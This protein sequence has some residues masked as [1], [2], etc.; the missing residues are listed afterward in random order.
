MTPSKMKV[1]FTEKSKPFETLKPGELFITP[2][3]E[4]G[5][6]TWGSLNTWGGKYKIRCTYKVIMS[7]GIQKHEGDILLGF[8]FPSDEPANDKVYGSN[9]EVSL[10]EIYKEVNTSL[11]S[12]LKSTE[13]DV[14]TADKLP[15][16][17]TM[18]PTM[19]EYRYLVDSLNS[20]NV[21]ELLKSIGDIVFFK[22]K[23]PN[24]LVEA[25]ES[26]IFQFGF[27]S[28]SESFFTYHNADTILDGVELIGDTGLSDALLLE[29]Q[30]EKY[31]QPHVVKLLFSS[32]SIVPKRISV[33]I[34][35]NGVGKSETLKAFCR[36]ALSYK[37][38]GLKL[39]T[40]E[41]GRPLINRIV[42]IASPGETNNTF[43]REHRKTQK[44]FYRK[45]T[46]TRKGT[47][48]ITSSLLR[49]ARGGERGEEKVGG[50]TRWN[51]F[52]N[53]LRKALS[54]DDIY[55]KLRNNDH[56]PLNKLQNPGDGRLEVWSSLKEGADPVA[57]VGSNFYALSSG[58][59]TF[60]KF[61][62]MCCLHIENGTFILMDEPETHMHP[63][64]ISDFITLLD[65]LLELT[66]S[67]AILSTHS[68]YFV[69]EVSS[70][71]VHIFKEN[72]YHG[73]SI[74][75]PR[76]RTFGADVDSISDFVFEEDIESSLTDKI[77]EKVKGRSFES[78]EAELRGEL[79]YAALM[80]LRA[81]LVD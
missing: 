35:K 28:N 55:L 37:D 46:M 50:L 72:T 11:L 15:R 27:L 12:Y 9:S 63:N 41:G 78:V 32:Y 68:A 25:V 53:T 58:Q 45:I 44:L 33:L 20:A 17:F 29:F 66:R 60:F 77:Y 2:V 69:R 1:F 39:S 13:E 73:V 38:S 75:N 21:D 5:M 64:M 71:Q 81:R 7:D 65:E 30:L 52:E 8:L 54:F 80:D 51:I 74:T 31:E 16:F 47:R 4:G 26:E 70:E 42:A 49:L 76:L 67:F 62:I 14:V 43:P 22:R 48:S 24:W 18:H 6:N 19:Q 40:P 56:F 79:S 57:K 34:G 23:G 3:N 36:G 59:L 10:I 61:A